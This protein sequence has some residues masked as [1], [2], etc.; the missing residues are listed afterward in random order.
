MIT[1]TCLEYYLYS[2]T[3]I[4]F[5][6][7][8]SS[9]VT[10]QPLIHSN[11]FSPT[12]VAVSQHS[13]IGMCPLLVH[14]RFC[15]R[16]WVIILVNNVELDQKEVTKYW[17]SATLVFFPLAA[18]QWCHC[19][20]KHC[21]DLSDLGEP[22]EETRRLAGTTFYAR[23]RVANGMYFV[24]GVWSYGCFSYDLHDNWQVWTNTI[25]QNVILV[26]SIRFS[27]FNSERY[28]SKLWDSF[29]NIHVWITTVSEISE[30]QAGKVNL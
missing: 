27:N 17:I 21:Y 26:L 20:N 19:Q 25:L 7:S 6:T 30:A 3:I 18:K 11:A 28:I 13:D 23:L 8:F 10:V 5:H 15:W 24:F 4:T 29:K 22:P 14:I 9:F 2:K 16:W 12:T 1:S